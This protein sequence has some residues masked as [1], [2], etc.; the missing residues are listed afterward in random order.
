MGAVSIGVNVKRE[1]DLI[2][3][4]MWIENISSIFVEDFD[5]I[6]SVGKCL[7]LQCSGTPYD[8]RWNSFVWIYRQGWAHYSRNRESR[9]DSYGS[10]CHTSTNFIRIFVPLNA[11]TFPAFERNWKPV[12]SALKIL[13]GS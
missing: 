3:S 8:F 12:L 13:V 7:T 4:K 2:F 1:L 11:K 5:V 10:H 9:H 6:H